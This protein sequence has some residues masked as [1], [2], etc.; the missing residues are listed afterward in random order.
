MPAA[1]FGPACCCRCAARRR[2]GRSGG[3][4][5]ASARTWATRGSR[6]C[7]CC[8]I[9]SGARSTR[10]PPTTRAG[11]TLRRRDVAPAARRHPALRRV[12]RPCCAT[13]HLRLLRSWRDGLRAALEWPASDRARADLV[14]RGARAPARSG[15]RRPRSVWR[16][17]SRWSENGDRAARPE[18]AADARRRPPHGGDAGA[19][20][21]ATTSTRSPARLADA[22]RARRLRRRQPA[23]SGRSC[24]PPI[25]AARPAVFDPGAFSPIAADDARALLACW[26]P[27][28]SPTSTRTCCRAR[29]CSPGSGASA[30]ARH[31]GP[32]SGAA[33]P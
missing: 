20:A 3:R 17:R 31:D 10:A 2:R 9:C 25:A 21:G 8:A 14:R 29:G 15:D 19:A 11:G 28:C 22:P 18:R 23:R 4:R 13:H 33:D 24:S 16:C 1:G 5:C 30:R 7:R 27:I 26:P 12:R 32:R 6:R